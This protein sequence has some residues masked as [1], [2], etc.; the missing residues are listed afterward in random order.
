MPK[1]SKKPK[2]GMRMFYLERLQDVH[3]VSGEGYVAEGVELS[4]GRVV[5]SWLTQH[6]TITIFDN[7]KEL[8]AIHSHGGKTVIKYYE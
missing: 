7:M 5:L 8:E 6:H 1:K 2:P 4:T 3:G